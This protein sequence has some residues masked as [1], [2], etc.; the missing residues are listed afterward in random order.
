VLPPGKEQ[1]TIP[2]AQS[3]VSEKLNPY[4]SH[5]LGRDIKTNEEYPQLITDWSI[6]PDGRTYTWD[7]R[8]NIPFYRHGAPLKDYTF[9]AQDLVLTWDLLI[10]TEGNVE[11]KNSRSPANWFQRMGGPEA[12][13]VV[14]DHKI[15]QHLPRVNLDMSFLYSDEWESG[16][17]SRQHWDDVG[18]E[19]G[20]MAD[21]VGNGPWTYISHEV[22]GTFHHKA[23][24][25]HWRKSPDFDEIK[26]IQVQEAAT[27]LAMLLA[28]EVHIIPLVRTQREQIESAGFTTFRST[29]PS[30]HQGIGFIYYREFAY[31]LDADG[32]VDPNGEPPPGGV[33]CGRSGGWSED[34]PIRNPKV[35]LAMNMAVNRNEINEVFYQGQ[36]FPLVDYFPP[37]RDDFQE[38]WAPVPG[39]EGKTGKAGGWPYAYDPAGAKALLAEAG[40]PNGFDTTLNC[41][42]SHRVIPEW[43]DICEKLVQDFKAIGITAG[44]DFVPDFGNFRTLTKTRANHDG[45]WMWSA[46][47]SLDPICQAVTFSMIWEMGQAYREFP[48]ASTFYERCTEITELAE[49]RELAIAFGDTW[50]SKAFSIPLMWVFAEVAVD[51][52]VVAEYQVNMLHMGPVRYHEFTKAVFK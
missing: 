27:R 33:A 37:W 38:R 12:W 25:D 34:I 44:L 19:D 6:L 29:L 43:P 50:T 45:N 51:P 42:L 31:C 7:L 1:F 28:E 17:L 22:L 21:P 35:R 14:N 49:R 46:S 11:T 13:T 10:G 5:L 23:V 26:M 9:S 4:Y 36:A 41:L 40:Y 39:P 24:K 15:I 47:P 48:E 52:N 32:N 16:I 20:Y 3:Q 30:V 2:Y 18:G 8:E